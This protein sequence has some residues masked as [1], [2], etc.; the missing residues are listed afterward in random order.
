MHF[1]KNVFNLRVEA[2]DWWHLGLTVVIKHDDHAMALY[3]HGGS[4]S[5]WY[6]YG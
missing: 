3:D 5:P 4:Y 2:H 6:D 1:L